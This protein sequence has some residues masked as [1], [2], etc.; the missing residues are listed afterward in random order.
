MAAMNIYVEGNIGTGKSTFLSYLEKNLDPEKFNIIYEPVDQWTALSDSNGKNILEH[1]Y[2]DQFKW[3]FPF[4]MNSFISRVK[5]IEEIS[6]L[7]PQKINIIERSV[8]TDKNCFALNCFNDGK[9]NEIE[10]KVYTQWHDWLC[11]H[12]NIKP[13]GF[14]YIKT[15][16]GECSERIERR[17]RGGEGGIPVEYLTNLGNLHDKWLENEENVFN[18]DMEHNLYEN[19]EKMEKIMEDLNEYFDKLN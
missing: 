4:Q 14:I 8:Y 15:P 19:K 1:F 5:N 13:S 2:E 6:N 17:S 12:F 10:F 9:I 3:A 7:R 18:I 11:K 16:P